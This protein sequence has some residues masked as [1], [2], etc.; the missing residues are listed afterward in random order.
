MRIKR[1]GV[2]DELLLPLAG[3]VVL[4]TVI[5]GIMVLVDVHGKLPLILE[6]LTR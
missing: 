4:L 5:L 6:A 1:G 2:V 3:A